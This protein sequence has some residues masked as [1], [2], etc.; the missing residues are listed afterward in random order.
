MNYP[1]WSRMER[2]RSGAPLLFL[3]VDSAQAERV[4]AIRLDVR[5]LTERVDSMFAAR[6][7]RMAA[8]KI[9]VPD[10]RTRD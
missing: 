3:S 2:L 8:V 6:L 5:E 9:G 10:Y 7:Y 4:N 1:S